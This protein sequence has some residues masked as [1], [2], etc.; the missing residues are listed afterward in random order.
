MTGPEHYRKAEE[1]LLVA[2][3]YEQDGAPKTGANRRADAQVHAILALAAA[4][5]TGAS[6][7]AYAAD[8]NSNDVTAWELT[9]GSTQ[10]VP[11][12]DDEDPDD[13]FT[14]ADLHEMDQHDEAALDAAAEAGD[15]R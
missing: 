15:P 3:A 1:L 8:I 10:P 4:T 7:A 13:G 6:V 11:D 2:I 14:A 12:E 5:A 9:A